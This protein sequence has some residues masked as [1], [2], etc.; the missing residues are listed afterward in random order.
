MDHKPI[1]PGTARAT[2]SSAER[3]DEFLHYIAE[4][5]GRERIT[6]KP[7]HPF[8]GVPD[9]WREYALD[10]E[11]RVEMFMDNWTALGGHAFRMK[12]MAEAK[13]FIQEF[14]QETGASKVLLQNQ[15]EL[16]DLQ[17][18]ELLADAE[19]L[20]WDSASEEMLQDA[21]QAE[22][23]IT[24]VDHAAAYT[25]TVVVRS[26]PDKG[27][28]TSLLPQALIAIVPADV[29][30]A[31]LG[32]ILKGLDA[33]PVQDLPA[34]V[35]FITGPSRSSDIENDLTIGVHGPGIVYAL[36]IG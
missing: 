19:C 27:R 6:T 36:V 17:L 14:V 9:Y 20:V 30:E 8:R 12:S 35:H 21:A 15:P 5:L 26:S 7:Q 34:G 33:E 22:V 13:T 31:N 10:A 3:Q 29:I 16:I 32:P 1:R 18:N 11:A 25:G 2:L 24:I 4:R 28:S 23:G